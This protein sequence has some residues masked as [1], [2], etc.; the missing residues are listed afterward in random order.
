ML[1]LPDLMQSVV[2]VPEIFPE[3]PYDF[4][5]FFSRSLLMLLHRQKYEVCVFGPLVM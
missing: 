3:P 4:L 2:H 5:G 1:E